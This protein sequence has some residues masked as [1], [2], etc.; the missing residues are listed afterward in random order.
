M[1]TRHRLKPYTIIKHNTENLAMSNADP[2][3][4]GLNPCPH[5]GYAVPVCYKTF[6]VL[7]HVKT[8]KIL[9]VI[10][11]CNDLHNRE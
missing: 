9:T 2:S 6:A 5:K 1:G 3:K 10:E 4:P 7:L 8:G 11:K